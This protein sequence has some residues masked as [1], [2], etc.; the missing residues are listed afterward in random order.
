[1]ISIRNIWAA[2]SEKF[3]NMLKKLD[4]ETD[5]MMYEPDERK[6]TP[7]EMTQRINESISNSSLLIVAEDNSEIV[8]FLSADRGFANRISI[9]HI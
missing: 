9:V 2:D 4:K 7:E 3:L 1:M 5:F 8:G 6:T